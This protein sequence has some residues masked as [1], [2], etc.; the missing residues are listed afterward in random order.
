MSDP[1]N[2]LLNS[3]GQA[4]EGVPTRADVIGATR[5]ENTPLAN[6]LE[7]KLPGNLIDAPPTLAFNRIREVKLPWADL[8]EAMASNADGAA[9]G[10]FPLRAY[11]ERSWWNEEGVRP[12]Q[13]QITQAMT[14]GWLILLPDAAGGRSFFR[15]AGADS[16]PE[17]LER[18]IVLRN[19]F[20]GRYYLIE[21]AGEPLPDVRTPGGYIAFWDKHVEAA[22]LVFASEDDV[23]R[24]Q[25]VFRELDL[26]AVYIERRYRELVELQRVVRSVSATASKALEEIIAMGRGVDLNF[27]A[28]EAVQARYISIRLNPYRIRRD[29][30]QLKRQA[31][32]M[33]YILFL[34]DEPGMAPSG[35][36]V[37]DG[38]APT[39]K[40]TFTFPN[41]RPNTVYA[42]ELYTSK[43]EDIKYTVKHSKSTVGN[44]FGRVGF[45]LTQFF[46][47]TDEKYESTW[48]EEKT[49][50]D[51][52]VY[53][54]LDMSGDPL[55]ECVEA[56][57]AQRKQVHV[58]TEN[59]VGLRVRRGLGAVHGDDAL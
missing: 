31:E 50:K 21:T 8:L 2:P 26:R 6:R 25:T 53:I 18:G 47:G 30:Q 1:Q 3:Y 22:T 4:F 40:K 51:V 7:V 16:P 32:K 14:N 23:G 9:N 36:P 15:Y 57:R 27:E 46:A 45:A 48:E 17:R 20:S 49:A 41:G 34:E 59:S 58:L 12:D 38:E 29:L 5:L 28:L 42:G 33:K 35:E 13:Q 56:Y 10:I 44:F 55:G 19:A 54:K 43:K 37:A 39:F 11:F 52:T 24:G